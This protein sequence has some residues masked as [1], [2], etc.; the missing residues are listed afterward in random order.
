MRYTPFSLFVKQAL[1]YPLASPF[2]PAEADV[3]SAVS[4]ANGKL[5]GSYA[6]VG[7]PLIFQPEP[8]LSMDFAAAAIYAEY[9]EIDG[10]TV[11]ENPQNIWH[12]PTIKELTSVIDYSIYNPAADETKVPGIQSDFY[13]SSTAYADYTSYAWS[14]GFYSGY[15]D[16]D[17]KTGNGYVRCVRQ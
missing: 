9:L 1:Q 17:V 15:V 13:W 6:P 16:Y 11:N 5:T 14:V 7:P 12:I 3:K 4:Y 10:V 2:L 8:T